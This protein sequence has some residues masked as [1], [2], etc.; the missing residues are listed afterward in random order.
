MQPMTQSPLPV[1]TFDYVIAGGGVIGINIAIELKKLIPQAKI[2]VLEKESVPAFHSS[3]RN[4]GVLHAGF[5]YTADSLKA[6]F[7]AEGNEFL[8]D[9]CRTKKLHLNPCG[10]LVVAKNQ[11]DFAQFPVLLERAKTNGVHLEEISLNE[12][13]K[14]EPRVKSYQKALWSPKT[15]TIDPKEVLSSFIEDAKAMG[16]VV[17]YTCTYL[18]NLNDN[19]ILTSLGVITFGYF[20]NAAGLYADKVAH[21]F[22]FAKDYRILPFKGL[23]LY[24]QTN[25]PKL[26]R[27]IYPVPNLRNP[28]LGVHHTVTVDGRSK[29]GPTA[30]PAFWREQYDGFSRFSLSEFIRILGDE[31]GLFFQAGFDF[32]SL[33]LEEIK[34]YSQSYLVNES[35][36]MLEGVDQSNYKKWGVPGIRAQLFNIHEKKLIMDF[37]FEGDSNSFHVLNA[38]SPA[39]TCSQPFAKYMVSKIME[40]QNDSSRKTDNHEKRNNSHLSQV[41]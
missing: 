3:G 29:I 28:F 6:R 16:I 36:S 13:K 25:G 2:A 26:T 5:Y 21:D 41:T 38:V 17:E 1:K 20:I 7:T 24:C 15:S 34:K 31:M 8:H 37:C 39:F 23:Y 18:K 27:H 10:K 12:A 9:Y 33:A 22:G 40:K 30:I 14:L 11:D 19:K 32:R 35:K 4:S